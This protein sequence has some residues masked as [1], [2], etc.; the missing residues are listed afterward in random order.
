MDNIYGADM[1]GWLIEQQGV[2][3]V[4]M[5]SGV[6]SVIFEEVDQAVLAYEVLSNF[7]IEENAVRQANVLIFV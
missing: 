5:T 2:V 1:H 7:Q 6:V 4:L 3:S